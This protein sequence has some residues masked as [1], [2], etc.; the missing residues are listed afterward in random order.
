MR[1]SLQHVEDETI[2]E[3]EQWV[4]RPV[5]EIFRF[6]CDENNLE[7]LTPPFL[8]FRVLGKSTPEI[9]EGTLIDYQL[10]LRGIPM[11]WRTR[12]DSWIPNQRFV[13]TQVRGPYRLWHH[14][15]SFQPEVRDGIDGTLLRDRVR[16]R[17]PF[18]LFG[19]AIAGAWVRKDV[20]GVFE[21]RHEAISR[22]FGTKTEHPLE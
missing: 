1:I 2:L 22:F 21:Y 17:L 11:R 5:S 6:F 14:T 16:F 10:R 8:G 18:G 12:I 15:H 3:A 13:D 20:R 4:P 19:E 9:E 7:A